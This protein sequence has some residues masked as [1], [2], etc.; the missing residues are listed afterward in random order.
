MSP[1]VSIIIPVF[2]NEISISE[3]IRSIRNQTY[4]NIEII[5]IDNGS[6]DNTIIVLEK[7]IQHDSRIKVYTKDTVDFIEAQKF[8]LKVAKGT[9]V[10]FFESGKLMSENL[11]E[12]FVS[13]LEKNPADIIVCDYFSTLEYYV[14][15]SVPITQTSPDEKIELVSNTKYLQKM[16]SS[17][18]HACTNCAVVW[19]KLIN[20]LWLLSTQY[21][22]TKD[23]VNISYNFL[24]KKSKILVTNQILICDVIYDKFLRDN[25]I[26]LDDLNAVEFLE[27]LLIKYKKQNLSTATFNTAER[28]L[29]FLLKLILNNVRDL[30][31]KFK[32]KLPTLPSS[33]DNANA[34]VVKYRYASDQK[35]FSEIM[36]NLQTTVEHEVPILRNTSSADLKKQAKKDKIKKRKGKNE[37]GNWALA[38]HWCNDVHG[39]K[40]IKG[41]NFP[42]SKE[43][44]IQYFQTLIKDANE[45]RLL[46]S[47]VIQ[48]A[49]NYFLETGIK[50]NLKG[51][52][53]T[54]E[55]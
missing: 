2:N 20:R 37:I 17:D 34:F 40:N 39:S 51:L 50:I 3:T 31:K 8:G 48:M 14:L 30:V 12:Y 16:Y 11:I 49:K 9:Y 41:E 26:N 4:T 43:A 7:Q 22:A 35:I 46:G 19:N 42:F 38:H 44:G 47:S 29:K 23:K 5:I 36:K 24:T 33:H 1:L 52:K 53:Y 10:M 18:D 6:L 54:S 15:N 27:S 55:Y 25:S 13:C 28:L 21:H 32:S 45:G